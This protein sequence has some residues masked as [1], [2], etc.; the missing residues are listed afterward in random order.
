MKKLILLMPIA[1]AML[2]SNVAIAQ[3]MPAGAVVTQIN[4]KLNDG[5]TMPQVVAWARSQPRNGPQPNAEYYREA[6]VNP[7]FLQNYNFQIATY[8]GSHSQVVEVA[9]A[10]ASAPANRVQS[11]VRATDLYTCDPAS[12]VVVTNRTV[13]QENDGFSGDATVMHTRFCRLDDGKTLA[14]AWK[15]ISTVAENYQRA[16][17]SSIIQL[18][19]RELGPV[20]MEALEN[21]GSG[22]TIAAVPATPQ[23]WGTRWDMGRDGSGFNATARTTQPFSNCNIPAVWVTNAVY[24]SAPPQ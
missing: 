24:R 15:F 1:I 23:D 3:D 6:V 10:N 13:N 4:C 12:N 22:V 9:L 5:V 16:G 11:A 20:P 2:F 14:D 19:T 21:A 17:S 7:N 8:Y 18:W